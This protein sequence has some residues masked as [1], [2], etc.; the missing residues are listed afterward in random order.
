[1][2][3][4]LYRERFS[5]AEIV[6]ITDLPESTIKAMLIRLRRLM[7]GYILESA[8]R[9]RETVDNRPTVETRGRKSYREH[10]SLARPSAYTRAPRANASTERWENEGGTVVSGYRR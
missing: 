7:P 3:I 2:L 10:V 4:L 9:L 8:D 6:Y 5:Y 1:M